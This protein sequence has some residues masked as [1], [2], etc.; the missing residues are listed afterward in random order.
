MQKN[1]ALATRA[2]RW[3]T[4]PT[5]GLPPA[6]GRRTLHVSASPALRVGIG[7]IGGCAAPPPTERAQR[8]RE[9]KN[10]WDRSAKSP[11]QKPTKPAAM[12]SPHKTQGQARRGGG[13]HRPDGARRRRAGEPDEGRH[14]AGGAAVE[15]G[16]HHAHPTLHEDCEAIHRARA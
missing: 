1:P 3:H 12:G 7:R 2:R 16:C 6:Q 13:L 10:T 4:L 5:R 15:G 14:G 9:D 11:A 8:A